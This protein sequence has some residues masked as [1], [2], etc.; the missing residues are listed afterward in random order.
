MIRVD[1]H[2]LIAAGVLI[3]GYRSN[4]VAQERDH[5]IADPACRDCG[6]VLLHD[7]TLGDDDGSGVLGV[8]SA[9]VVDSR[10][11]FLV[12]SSADVS[13]ILVFSPRGQL[14]RRL[15]REGSGPGEYRLIQ[16]LLVDADDSVHVFD[17]ITR[18]QTILA[19]DGA[20]ARSS[21]LLG[22]TLGAIITGDGQVV[23]NAVI[24]DRGHLGFPLHLLQ[25][26]G[27]DLRSFGS[28]DGRSDPTEPYAGRRVIAPARDGGVWSAEVG[29]Y[30]ISKW[31]LD[32]TESVSFS[33]VTSWFP[34][35]PM[36]PIFTPDRPPASTVTALWEDAQG[37]LWILL[38]VGDPHWREHIREL[39]ADY[40]IEREWQPEDL[41]GVFDT[42][43]EVIDTRTG[44]LVAST[45]VP[46]FLQGFL[47]DGRPFSNRSAPS[48][49]IKI[50]V[51]RALLESAG[52]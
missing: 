5:P 40:L 38:T 35:E 37:H 29:R 18:R 12:A 2:A 7:V 32:G 34:R 28:R 16:R 47:A 15:G 45:K 39:K 20:F 31:S 50:D 52:Q 22:S 8:T 23:Q 41:E 46:Y 10:G 3:L 36:N 19:P 17:G 42:I 30:R 51:F 14:L 13:H 48:G 11:Q 27:Y 9:V 1:M 24:P 6:V 49:W 33:R 25:P 44:R 4:L 26:N 21:P 43:V